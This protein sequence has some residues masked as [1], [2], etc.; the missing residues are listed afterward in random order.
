MA[1]LDEDDIKDDWIIKAKTTWEESNFHFQKEVD[2]FFN[3]LMLHFFKSFS[4]ST[5]FLHFGPNIWNEDI[6]F[7]NGQKIAKH[8]KV[9]NDTAKRGYYVY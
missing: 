2:C 9:V 4:I 8:P 3:S 1:D 6:D 5:Y 7:L